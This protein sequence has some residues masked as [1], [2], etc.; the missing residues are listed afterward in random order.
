MGLDFVFI[1]TEH[2][3]V[4]DH[5]LSW[6]CQ[7]YNA[8]ELTPLVRIPEPDPYRATKVL[9]GGAGGVIA[10]YVES[11]E[12]VR[13]L[14]GAVALRP[15]KGRKLA[16]ALEGRAHMGDELKQY[17]RQ[18]NDGKLLI[19][20]IESAPAVDHL[21]ELLTAA[22]LDAVLI[23]PHDLSVSME[24]PEQYHHTEFDKMV[25][26]IIDRSRFH[27]IG[28]GI[29]FWEDL[30]QEIE[31]ARHG[32]NVFLHSADVLLIAR[33]LRN[34]LARA[35]SALADRVEENVEVEDPI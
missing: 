32:A 27:G 4:D 34:D 7:V 35:R 21:D 31:W 20:N 23:G 12:Q 26:L 1:D 2:L 8:M 25:R 9:D 29:H 14:Y 10:P 28:V 3:L 22:E 16:N 17:L 6:M 19:I 18:R 5:D 13:A 24:I 15:L 33:A 11:V 30:E